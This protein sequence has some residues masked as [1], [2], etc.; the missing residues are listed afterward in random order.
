MNES[1]DPLDM[2]ISMWDSFAQNAFANVEVF[3]LLFW[4]KYKER[5]GDVI[6]EYYQLF[7]D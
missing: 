6:F 2:L 4:G 3:E 1:S 5:L 7:P